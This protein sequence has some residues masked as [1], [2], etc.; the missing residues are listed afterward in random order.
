MQTE[1]L[2]F[3]RE[4]LCS[5][6]RKAAFSRATQLSKSDTVKGRMLGRNGKGNTSC[7]L[8]SPFLLGWRAREL[9]MVF[10]ISTCSSSRSSVSSMASSSS[11]G[12][13]TESFS[14]IGLASADMSCITRVASWGFRQDRGK[15]RAT[16][17]MCGR[18]KAP[19]L[20]QKR[21]G[22]VS[23]GT[24]PACK[25]FRNCGDELCIKSRR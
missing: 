20:S 5:G 4:H 14:L 10:W 11:K 22:Q 15:C 18:R 16:I 3:S 19:G 13:G 21:T 9:E 25:G 6:L 2:T 17:N 24:R 23:R 12:S 7:T 8:M 1:T